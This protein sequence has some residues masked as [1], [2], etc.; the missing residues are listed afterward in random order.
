MNHYEVK[1]LPETHTYVVQIP[2][3]DN[4]GSRLF[5]LLQ[6]LCTRFFNIRLQQI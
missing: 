1:M 3:K 5:R 2:Y 4:S 6:K